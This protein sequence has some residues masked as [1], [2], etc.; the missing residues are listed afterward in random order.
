M[1]VAELP[2][3]DDFFE[4]LRRVQPDACILDCKF[5]RDVAAEATVR[6]TVP[7]PL[8]K[9]DGFFGS[10]VCDG[11]CSRQCSEAL[12]SYL[13][14]E[15][16]GLKELEVATRGQAA[17]TFWHQAR[18]GLLTASNFRLFC[19]CRDGAHTATSLLQKQDF[20]PNVLPPPIAYG[21]KHE[22]TARQ[23]FIKGHKYR[24]RNCSV[25]VPGLIV[26][27]SCPFLGCSPDGL[28]TCK[29]CGDFLIE[30]K[31]LWSYRNFHPKTAAVMSGICDKTSDGELAM[32]FNHKHYYQIQGQM[33]VTGIHKSFLVIFTNKGVASVT[34]PFD[35]TF[36]DSRCSELTAFYHEH[37]YIALQARYRTAHDT[38]LVT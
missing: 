2:P 23:M 8:Q 17:N 22:E 34:V 1:P 29:F 19:H 26:S 37:M 18:V 9:I 32:N 4:G 12:V 27:S 6:P 14:Y 36:W 24:H 30:I 16:R 21:R 38:S 5:S 7:L 3:A 33:A 15:D 25:T 20:N 31:C 11:P 13:R 35:V 28:V 10:H